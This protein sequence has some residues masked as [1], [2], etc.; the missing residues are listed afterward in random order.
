ADGHA[1]ARPG[2]A[3]PGQAARRPGRGT[4]RRGVSAWPGAAATVGRKMTWGCACLPGPP[5]SPTQRRPMT[6][7]QSIARRRDLFFQLHE[8]GCFVIPN[9]WNIGTA[10]ILQDLGFKAIAS[11]SAG[12]AHANGLPDGAEG[13]EEVLAHYE[14]MA[15]AVDIPLNA[16]FENGFAEDLQ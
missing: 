2:M 8:K 14:A 4:A 12:H 1:D 16:D 10:R 6:E 11:T 7:S 5:S 9:P 3:C 13:L 15:A